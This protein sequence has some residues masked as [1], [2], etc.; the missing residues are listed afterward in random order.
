MS[1]HKVAD[2]AGVS[3]ST[4]SRVINNNPRVAPA[5]VD[6]VKQAMSKLGYTPSDRRPGPKPASQRVGTAT[7][8]FLVLGTSPDRATPAFQD[9]LYGVSTGASQM[10]ADLIFGHVPDAEH[11]PVRLLDK[12]VDGL[13][14]HGA[15]PTGVLRD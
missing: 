15:T 3:A 14:L 8:A 13:L 12:K 9:L 2:L 7:I 11:L 4:I 6:V 10:D 1:I 5:T